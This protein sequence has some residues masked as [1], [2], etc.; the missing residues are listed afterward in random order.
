MTSMTRCHSGMTESPSV[1]I[2][3]S[4][5]C[6]DCS[7]AAACSRSSESSGRVHLEELD[8]A[9]GMPVD[10]GAGPAQHRWREVDADEP[11]GRSDASLDQPE[12]AAGAAGNVED[13][14]AKGDVRKPEG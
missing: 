5:R 1:Q 7:V 14:A 9:P 4:K 6:Q 8:A 3:A 2:A 12:V 11:A 10:V 13:R